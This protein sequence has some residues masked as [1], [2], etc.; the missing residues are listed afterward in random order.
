[1]FA[2]VYGTVKYLGERVKSILEVRDG[3][4]SD[5]IEDMVRQLQARLSTGSPAT[6]GPT[7]MPD[8]SSPSMLD[9][10]CDVEFSSD[11]GCFYKPAAG[12]AG[13]AAGVMVRIAFLICLMSIA[14]NVEAWL[15][16]LNDNRQGLGS[17]LSFATVA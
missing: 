6:P 3:D 2:I 4:N 14:P 17:V 1:M 13:W 16:L 5:V 7:S 8:D 12:Q 10:T 9:T 11:A 15:L